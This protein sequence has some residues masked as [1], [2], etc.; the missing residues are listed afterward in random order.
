V[1][2]AEIRSVIIGLTLAVDEQ[3]VILFVVIIFHRKS[4]LRS[5]MTLADNQK[6]SK[7]SVLDPD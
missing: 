3:F 1:D 2:I 6:C 5:D 7:D 4:L